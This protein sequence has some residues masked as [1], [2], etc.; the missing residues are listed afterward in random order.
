MFRDVTLSILIAVA[1]VVMVHVVVLA[2][3]AYPATMP[4][5]DVWFSTIGP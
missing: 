2:A 5:P 1:F 4:D 3:A